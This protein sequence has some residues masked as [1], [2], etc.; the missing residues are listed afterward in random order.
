MVSEFLQLKN[1]PVLK[2]YKVYVEP[3][4]YTIHYDWSHNR[5]EG[6][7]ILIATSEKG[8]LSYQEFSDI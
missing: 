8:L 4:T 7:A 1:D 3:W 5:I 6:H 2:V